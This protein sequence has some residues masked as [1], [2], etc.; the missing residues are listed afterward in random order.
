MYYL[1]DIVDDKKM[2]DAIQFLIFDDEGIRSTCIYVIFNCLH[3]TCVIKRARYISYR[4]I[5]RDIHIRI[6]NP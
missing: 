1:K 6:K 3:W 2:R 5:F 4:N